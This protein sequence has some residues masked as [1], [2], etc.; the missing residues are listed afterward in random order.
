LRATLLRCRADNPTG[1]FCQFLGH[2]RGSLLEAETQ[3]LLSERL[4]YVSV[5][6]A[7]SLLAGSAELGKILNG[8]IASMQEARR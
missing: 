5:P 7:E 2:A 4:Q 6:D 1:E 3:I 8:L